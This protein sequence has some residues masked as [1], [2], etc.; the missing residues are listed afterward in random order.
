MIEKAIEALKEKDIYS[1]ERM[2]ILVIPV[3]KEDV[4]DLDKIASNM[5]KIL[6]SIGFNKSWQ[7]DPYYYERKESVIG[8]MYGNNK[9]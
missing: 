9:E 7:L 2:G 8:E 5:K 4:K 1:F 3:R 6:V